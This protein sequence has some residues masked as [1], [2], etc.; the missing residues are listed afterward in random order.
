VTLWLDVKATIR[1][2]LHPT[3]VDEDTP[4]P[5]Y[6]QAIVIRDWVAKHRRTE[7]EAS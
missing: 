1:E 7:G 2:F 3:P 4:D 6:D 5:S